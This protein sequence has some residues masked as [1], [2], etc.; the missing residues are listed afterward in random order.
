MVHTSYSTVFKVCMQAA[1]ALDRACDCTHTRTWPAERNETIPGYYCTAFVLR[2]P[3]SMYAGAP[4]RHV[5]K[6]CRRR[7]QEPGASTSGRAGQ[8]DGATERLQFITA[9]WVGVLRKLQS[10][11]VPCRGPELLV[12]RQSSIVSSQAWAA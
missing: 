10:T 9:Q 1:G 8:D 7:N 3:Y 5:M 6:K 4:A 12:N 2:T 11:V